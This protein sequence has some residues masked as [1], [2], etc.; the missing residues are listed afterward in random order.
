MEDPT[1][2]AAW[3]LRDQPSW[4]RQAV[5]A[6][7]QGRVTSRAWL[8]RPIPVVIVYTTAVAAP[9]GNAWFYPD[10]YGHDGTLDEALRAGPTD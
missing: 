3:V 10:I 4:S 7:Q 6:A 1:A 9:D 2:L 5:I 8:T